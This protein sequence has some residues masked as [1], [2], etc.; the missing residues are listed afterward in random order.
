MEKKLQINFLQLLNQKV[1]KNKYLKK[2]LKYIYL[3][4]IIII[5]K[6]LNKL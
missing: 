6:Y 5:K 2:P 4:M 1:T 3:F